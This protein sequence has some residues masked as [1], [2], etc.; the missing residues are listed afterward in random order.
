MITFRSTA[1]ITT[2]TVTIPKP[3]VSTSIR[4]SEARATQT[5]ILTRTT[6]LST[7]NRTSSKTIQSLETTAPSAIQ[8]QDSE[9]TSGLKKNNFKAS[10][11]SSSILITKIT[12][13]NWIEILF[14]NIN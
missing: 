5:S 9:T 7:A 1:A 8:S 10:S 11:Q 14:S 3:F 12:S 6:T 13:G 2:S 4:T